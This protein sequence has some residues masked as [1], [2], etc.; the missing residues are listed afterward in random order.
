V[1]VYKILKENAFLLFE[2]DES[3]YQGIL[4]FSWVEVLSIGV[5]TSFFIVE[6][7]FF[8]SYKVTCKIFVYVDVYELLKDYS[9]LLVWSCESIY[10]GVWLWVEQQ[11]FEM[12]SHR[13]FHYRT[14][15]FW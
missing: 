10:Q 14:W 8:Y 15:F 6:S 9:F 7:W 3:I 1:D 13:I 12:E 2:C 4:A 11:F 5:F